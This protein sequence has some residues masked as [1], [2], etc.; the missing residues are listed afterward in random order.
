MDKT[1]IAMTFMICVAAVFIAMFWSKCSQIDVEFRCEGGDE[2]CFEM[3][4]RALRNGRR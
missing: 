2:K 1:A 3:V 4:E